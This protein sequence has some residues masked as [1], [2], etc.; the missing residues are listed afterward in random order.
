MLRVR[1]DGGALTTEQLRP[2]ARSARR[3]P[4]TPPT[5]PTGRTSSTTGSRSRTCRRSGSAWR[6]SACITTEA[7][8]DTPRVI[9]GSPVAGIAADE[10][11]DPHARDRRDPRALHRQQGV[12]QPAAQVQDRDLLAAGRRPRGQRRLVHRRR[13]PRARPR[14]RPVGRR[15]PVDQ[16]DDRAAARRLGAARR[17]PG[18]L[19]GRHLDLPRLRL[20]AAAA[21]RPDQVPGRR[22]GRREVPPGAGGRVP[23]PDADR[24]PGARDPGAPDRPRRRAPAEGRAATTSASRRRPAGCPAPRSSP[25]PTRRRRPAP[26]ACGSPRSR[27]SSCSTS[28]TSGSTRSR[29]R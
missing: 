10:V 13:A 25:S 1:L 24:R 4:A 26:G 5:S 21:P 27:R 12:L 14:L 22:L 2:S 8:G 7:C 15:R 3:T 29:P 17:G 19:G 6:A 11:I 18:R 23:A 16:P 28:R 9:L 20:P